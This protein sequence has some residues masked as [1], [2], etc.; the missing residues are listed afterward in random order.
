MLAEQLRR[1][2]AE[3]AAAGV[4]SPDVDAELLAAHALRLELAELRLRRARGDELTLGEE[5]WQLIAERARRVPVQHLTGVAD[6]AGCSLSVGPGVFIPRP[7]TEVLAQAA[8]DRARELTDPDALLIVD[9]CTG[10]GA[11]AIALA[12]A[13]PTSRVIG[14]EL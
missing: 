14:V 2:G 13:L 12:R 7:E 5:F 3:L 11:L 9:L 6:F 1:A 10:S 8:I 4:P